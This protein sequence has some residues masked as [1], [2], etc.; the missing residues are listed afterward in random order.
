[1]CFTAEETALIDGIIVSYFAPQ[2][3]SEPIRLRYFKTH[4]HL[5]EETIDRTDL[6]NIRSALLFLAPEFRDSV[7]T[8][9]E[10]QSLIAKTSSLLSKHKKRK[11]GG[12]PEK[13]SGPPPFSQYFQKKYS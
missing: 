3:V 12:D 13:A 7:Q 9:K 6:L 11:K 4:K 2:S 8:G 5:Q 1:M 10:I